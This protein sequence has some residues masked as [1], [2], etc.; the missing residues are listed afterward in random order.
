MNGV[1]TSIVHPDQAGFMPNKSTA[2]NLRR[3]HLTMQSLAD[4][5]GQRALLSLDAMKAFDSI[6]VEYLWGVLQRFGFRET[7]IS[8]VHLL[9]LLSAG[10]Y[11]GI[12][13]IIPCFCPR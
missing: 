6:E 5:I 8:R 3:L 13:Q 4:N 12:G 1:I 2:V 9:L 7:Y 10:S 11:P